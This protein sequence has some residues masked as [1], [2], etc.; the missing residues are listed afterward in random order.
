MALL[1][2]TS[3]VNVTEKVCVWRSIIF[4]CSIGSGRFNPS[5]TPPRRVTGRPLNASGNLL[6][7]VYGVLHDNKR[8]SYGHEAF[9]TRQEQ[10]EKQLLHLIADKVPLY[11]TS[12]SLNLTLHTFNYK[13]TKMLSAKVGLTAV[14][15]EVQV[16]LFRSTQKAPLS[17]LTSN[18]VPNC[19]SL[20]YQRARHAQVEHK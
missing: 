3:R 16:S 9:I 12:R 14:I 5:A 11:M 18:R 2:R 8:R 1:L 7:R 6:S 10:P 17:V 13:A 20:E 4:F 19:L 15:R